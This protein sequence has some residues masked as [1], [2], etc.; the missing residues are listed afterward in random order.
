MS[1]NLKWLLLIPVV[2][3]A[4]AL[5]YLIPKLLGG[6]DDERPSTKQQQSQALQL[7]IDEIQGR[8][9]AYEGILSRNTADVDALR[10]LA[11]S[12]RELGALQGEN[13]EFNDS[14]QSNK[15]AVDYYRK[16]LAARPDE[17]EARIDLG[18]TYFYMQMP[19]IGER[20]LKAVV[21]AAPAN[22]RAWHALAWVLENGLG[23]T[24]E[25]RQAWQ[26][27][28]NIDPN[29]SIGRESKQF[30]DQ[31]SSSQTQVPVP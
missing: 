14:Y 20:E 27:S 13:N 8:I 12:Y 30:L 2:I 3:V 6:D 25:A 24:D 5:G 19:E 23:K 11:D 29:S 15:L 21:Q 17:L 28:Y 9:G 26:N 1:D 22:Q 10:G 4:I 16:F 31:L 7:D 18:L